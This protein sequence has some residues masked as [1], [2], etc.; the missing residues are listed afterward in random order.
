MTKKII[1]LILLLGLALGMQ[2]QDAS[3]MDQIKLAIQA[4]N[5]KVLSN[6]F[7]SMLEVK[8]DSKQSSYS[9]NQ[10]YYVVKDFF[11]SHPAKSF[12]VDHK[13]QSPGGSTYAIGTYKS[14]HG[15]FR[16]YIKLASVN[17][18]KFIDTI[19]FTKE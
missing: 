15:D 12:Q 4:G 9:K 6:Y 13:G 8:V 10:A 18:K 2:A 11:K 5:S 16:V 14:I 3:R 1:T 19:E 7:S 17:G